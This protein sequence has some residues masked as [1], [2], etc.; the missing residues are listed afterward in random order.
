L[1]KCQKNFTLG[2]GI[3]EK[4][5][6]DGNEDQP[7]TPQDRVDFSGYFAVCV[8]I[9]IYFGRGVLH[10]P[11]LSADICSI[12]LFFASNISKW[13]MGERDWKKE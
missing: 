13:R 3:R 12:T 5:G 4:N 10:L 7:G 11:F 2:S 8:G 1:Y 6:R 9:A